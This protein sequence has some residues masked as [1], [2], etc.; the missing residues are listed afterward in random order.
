MPYRRNPDG[1]W[2]LPDQIDGHDLVCLSIP[3]PDN[4]EHRAAFWGALNLLC[5]WW[6]WQREDYPNERAHAAAQY[7]LELLTPLQVSAECAADIA[8]YWE[9][10]TAEDAD[11]QEPQ[12]ED[13]PWYENLADFV[14]TSFLA[15]TFTPGAA[16]TFVTTIRKGR[17]LFRRRN[18]GS[19]VKVF[20]DGLLQSEVDTYS[21]DGDIVAYD[22]E[23]PAL[24]AAASA[25]IA[26]FSA[27]DV[28]T[29]VI[30][31]EHSGTAN[32][33]AVPTA[34]GYGMEVIRK[35]LSEAELLEGED[36]VEVRVSD[37][38]LQWRT[39]SGAWVDL[40]DLLTLKGAKGDQGE[41]GLQG[42]QGLQ[43]VK[44]DK[45]DP[46]E[47]GAAGCCPDEPDTSTNVT[48]DICG[49]VT[50]LV[51]YLVA[52]TDDVLDAV[53]LGGALA[54]AVKN[55]IDLFSPGTTN[56]V[57]IITTAVTSIISVGTS[58]LRAL[59][60]VEAENEIREALY[61]L[62]TTG[63]NGFTTA[64]LDQWQ[65]EALTVNTWKSTVASISH[66]ITDQEHKTQYYL[67][68]LAPSS[69]CESAYD[70]T[71]PD[72]G[73]WCYEWTGAALGDW[74]EN[75]GGEGNFNGN[76][77]DS[78]IY[79]TSYHAVFI[80]MP[81]PAGVGVTSMSVQ[82]DAADAPPLAGTLAIR[83]SNGTGSRVYTFY[84]ASMPRGQNQSVTGNGEYTTLSS[85]AAIIEMTQTGTAGFRIEKIVMHG[86]G[87]N[88]FAVADNCT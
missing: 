5:D 58:A 15:T 4:P 56:V 60:T 78:T 50:A 44:G 22:Y 53:D 73:I 77:W 49:G 54:S 32:P 65:A 64:I 88:P 27:Q 42:I 47:D 61:C 79:N 67:G 21:A 71:P 9:D 59:H 36:A 57:D 41:T 17:L 52:K 62:I 43:G 80:K 12:L 23:V 26:T 48:D 83:G 38:V 24:P 84:N 72:D 82:Y 1:G 87:E 30:R 46:G 25:Q 37:D 74:L 85:Q 14:V 2:R 35:R 8:P 40:Y 6:N 45:G 7:W 20:I 39:G 3:I 10:E 11:D 68:T 51:D 70:C 69:V 75:F 29:H 86:T 19:L 18:F 31:I 16:I 66:Y 63:G 81:I 28:E 34:Q 33:A 13:F 55:V 76:E